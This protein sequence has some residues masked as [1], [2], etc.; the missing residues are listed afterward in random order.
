M[1]KP[2]GDKFGD[3]CHRNLDRHWTQ[4]TT[5]GRGAISSRQVRRRRDISDLIASNSVSRFNRRG[6]ETR[7]QSNQRGSLPTQEAEPNVIDFSQLGSSSHAL[8]HPCCCHET[9]RRVHRLELPAV[10]ELGKQ[11]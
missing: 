9:L 11:L 4:C 1:R 10:A 2:F 6:I 3:A 7:F 5:Y 8:L